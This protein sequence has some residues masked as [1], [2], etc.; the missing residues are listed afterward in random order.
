METKLEKDRPSKWNSIGAVALGILVYS[1]QLQ[2]S[3]ILSWVPVNVT[4]V[5]AG[6]AVAAFLLTFL[7]QTLTPLIFVP[8]G[9]W[10]S[11]M[12]PAMFRVTSE[13][14]D[15]KFYIL[16]TLTLICALAPFQI[17]R[18]HTQRVAFVM[19]LTVSAILSGILTL[20]TGDTAAALSGLST[21]VLILEGA[22]T[23]GTARIAGTG[24][25]ILLVFA[26][27]SNPSSRS[28]L[29]GRR[30]WFLIFGLA[31]AWVMISTGSR[32]PL[33]GIIAGIAFVVLLARIVKRRRIRT[34]VLLGAAIWGAYKW[35]ESKGF[36][37]SD[38]SFAWLAGERDTST[39]AREDLW[40]IASNYAGL[41]PFGTGWGGFNDL[42][43]VPS[44][45]AYPHNL[46]LEVYVEAGWLIGTLTL[47]FVVFSLWRLMVRSTSPVDAVFFALAVFT[48]T[49][50][51]VSGDINDNRLMWVVLGAAWVMPPVESISPATPSTLGYKG[52]RT[53]RPAIS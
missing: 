15:A 40:S 50:A 36:V 38:R 2:A 48:V 37:S 49:N 45:I 24:A 1:G 35:A 14:G 33:A 22:N 10:A 3:P 51:M 6:I 46:F 12:L 44:E 13:Y 4:Y 5:A 29:R 21:E 41:N 28:L 20:T 9:L 7:R 30:F 31:L 25:L 34:L 27:T 19:T 23:I 32:G 17:L 18:S 53:R 47:L 11:F 8:I 39:A 43:Y 26:I 42:P 16:M 52:R